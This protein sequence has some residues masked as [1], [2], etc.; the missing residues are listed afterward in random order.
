MT[1]WLRGNGERS[2]PGSQPDS[3]V[4]PGS[5]AET[6]LHCRSGGIRWLQTVGA[7]AKATAA[8]TPA[9]TPATEA[10][11]LH[12]LRMPL[13]LLWGED[14][15]HLGAHGLPH[16]L[17]FQLLILE[18]IP[19]LALLFRAEPKHGRHTLDPEIDIR[20]WPTPSG[21]LSRAITAPG[22]G[23][24]GRRDRHQTDG[25]GAE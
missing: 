24:S 8:A 20:A 5:L 4:E 21:P 6:N 22:L 2:P 10:A 13:T 14:G 12:H 16:G 15:I 3:L 9:G 1:S 11:A 25:T 19:E 18:D 7:R 23:Q 17:P